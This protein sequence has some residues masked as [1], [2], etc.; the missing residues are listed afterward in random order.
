MGEFPAE[1]PRTLDT[2]D[3]V[4]PDAPCLLVYVNALAGGFVIPRDEAQEYIQARMQQRTDHYTDWQVGQCERC[5]AAFEL[6]QGGSAVAWRRGP[7]HA[8]A[9]IAMQ[10][11]PDSKPED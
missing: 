5:P 7:C 3:E 8:M 2:A 11:R 1:S 10:M 4:Q 9:K 6:H